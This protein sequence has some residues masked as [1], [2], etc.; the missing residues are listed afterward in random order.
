M[1]SE[2]TK[3]PAIIGAPVPRVDGPL[4]VS[5][6]AMYTSDFHFPGMVYAVPVCSTVAKGRITRLDTSEAEKMVGVVAILH[7]ENIGKLY[8]SAPDQTFSAYLDEKRPPLED[9]II[10]YGGQYVA[11][12]VAETFEQAQAAAAAVTVIYSE[13]K[14]EVSDRLEPEG[15]MKTGSTRGDSEA[16]FAI[17]PVKIDETYV[18]PKKTRATV[19]FFFSSSSRMLEDRIGK[20]WL[21]KANTCGGFNA[22]RR[23]HFGLGDGC[24]LVDC[25]AL[26]L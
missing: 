4:K 14:P 11:L 5:G 22:R 8:R 1:A 23:S 24:L 9:D 20:I 25:R 13:E 10:S 19:Y 3:P 26:P 12:A 6:N 18:S 21:E 15:E 17:A 7:R 16:A 2:Q